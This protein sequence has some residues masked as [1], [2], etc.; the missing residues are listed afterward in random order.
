[1]LRR[2]WL[3]ATATVVVALVGGLLLDASV[4]FAGAPTVELTVEETGTGLGEV[5]SSPAG[6]AC[7]QTCGSSFEEG[8]TVTLKETPAAGSVFAGWE[9]C[10]AEP[11]GECEVTMSAPTTVRASFSEVP[12]PPAIEGESVSTLAQTTAGLSGTVN[13]K[14]QPVT[15]CVFDYALEEALLA[16]SPSSVECTPPAGELGEGEAG[17][18]VSASLEGL[19]ANTVYFYRLKAANGTGTEEGPVQQLLTL[20]DPP[21]VSTQEASQVGRYAATL[22]ATVNPAAAGHAEQDDTTYFFEYSTD[23]S[24]S[25]QTPLTP[26]DAGEGTSP[27]AV[28]AQ[29]E[30]LEPGTT[31]HYRIVASNDNAGTPQR[32]FGQARTFTT[33][34]TPPILAGTAASQVSQSSAFIIS[35]LNPQ[36]LPT[37]WEL[38][39]GTSPQALQPEAAGNSSSPEPE[40]LV[41]ALE[42]L[43]PGVTYYYRLTAENPNGAIGTPILSFTTAPAPPAPQPGQGANIPLL[44]IP[45]NIFPDEKP[46]TTPTTQ[47]LT[48]KQKLAK[49][50]KTCRRK[51][52]KHKRVTCD[53]QARRRY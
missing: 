46:T 29:L 34:A 8:Q 4:A 43:Q 44:G 24:F 50:L 53:K 3:L 32:V 51:H 39:L 21:V 36:G 7:G 11:A 35:A 23:E 6:I 48:R 38:K 18:G 20:P 47:P 42:H 49:A 17:V 45:A 12:T 28:E 13:P 37:R 16:S 15:A 30:G 9:G 2:F 27:V 31:Y 33:V 1:M 22:N 52:N 26:G 5:V 10:Q 25:T 19:L 14:R 41:L 40:A